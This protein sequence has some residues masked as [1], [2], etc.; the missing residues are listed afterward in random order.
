M[1]NAER[2]SSSSASSGLP[3]QESER[4][5]SQHAQAPVVTS[6]CSEHRGM[7]EA[8]VVRCGRENTPSGDDRNWPGVVTAA[9]PAPAGQAAHVSEL[10]R[11]RKENAHL[12]RELEGKSQENES[13][14]GR[15]KAE[16]HLH[17]HALEEL[18]Q[19]KRQVIGL[20]AELSRANDKARLSEQRWREKERS[21]EKRECVLVGVIEELRLENS[22]LREKV[23][24]LE[25][26]NARL[27]ALLDGQEKRADQLEAAVKK[28]CLEQ[29]DR[30]WCMLVLRYAKTV[31]ERAIQSLWPGVRSSSCTRS[32]SNCVD[33]L[34]WARGQ[35]DCGASKVPFE[36]EDA[37]DEFGRLSAVEQRAAIGRLGALLDHPGF[38]RLRGAL[39]EVRIECESGYPVPTFASQQDVSIDDLVAFCES[40]L[41]QLVKPLQLIR[42]FHESDFLGPKPKQ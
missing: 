15:L 12:W 7:T 22:N 24:R 33:I 20:T 16:A 38:R 30:Q 10:S 32:L 39:M 29:R 40:K 23:G 14:A 2:H 17:R 8:D 1:A 26:D 28:L 18:A 21:W 9:A 5:L 13:L 6:P 37:W 3:V 19:E 34:S 42:Q 4:G 31:E 11:L 27:L 35:Q 36:H 25:V 41:P